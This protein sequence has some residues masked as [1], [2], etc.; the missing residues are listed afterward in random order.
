VI[1]VKTRLFYG[2]GGAVYAVKESAY[3]MFILLFYTQ[4]LGLSGV[5]TGII[6][7]L[8]LVWDAV[9]DPLVGALSDRF[10]SRF[11]RRHP[12]MVASAIP[13]GLG[14]IGL[15]APPDSVVQSEVQLAAWLLFWSLWV[16]TFVTIFAIPHLALS[17][18][19]TSDYRDRSQVLGARM[20]FLFL[21]SVLI[22]ALALS[23]IFVDINGLDG[24]FVSDNYPLYGVLS[25]AVVWLMASVTILGTRQFIQPSQTAVGSS[26]P[27][28]SLRAI[29]QDLQR[30]FRNKTFRLVIGYELAAS[31]SYGT[32]V[33][34]NMIAWTYFWEFSAG[35]I[36]LILAVPSILAIGLVMLTLGP[37]V[38]RLQ[39]NRLLL[40]SLIAL[41]LNML[42][43]YPLRV[44]DLLPPNGSSAI[45]W[46]NFVFMLL[47]MY[48]FL[49]RAI[50]S[51][52]IVADISDEHELEQGVRQEAAFFAMTNFLHKFASITGPL[53]TG[54]V[55]ELIGLKEGMLPGE[56]PESILNQL[57][58]ALGIGAVPAL[59]LALIFVFRIRM[60]RA[61]VEAIQRALSERSNNT[62]HQHGPS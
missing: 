56:V 14:F 11:G 52:S 8:S 9:S 59:L 53:Y 37:L 13:M 29:L 32:T 47:F 16:R 51:H 46:L 10:S 48:A 4:V 6:I 12:Y 39:K 19:I 28:H 54:I 31:V 49:L 55:L 50:C 23:T 27:T 7:A 58:F 42:W 34:L 18:E 2:A 43:L 44:L 38:D 3:T 20:A 5:T 36:A 26:R 45:F 61:G 22:P 24:R 30:T 60:D 15:F 21:F 35:D 41:I 25:C 17:A 1:P 33:T 62:A 40:Y 57:V